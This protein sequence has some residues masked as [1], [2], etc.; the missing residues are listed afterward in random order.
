MPPVQSHRHLSEPQTPAIIVYPNRRRTRL[1]LF[2]GAVSSLLALLLFV[3][4]LILIIVIPATR[5]GG[6]I[7]TAVLLGGC[8]IAALWPTRLLASV[9]SSGEPMLVITH[10]VIRVG[11]VYGSFEIMLPWEEIEAIYLFGGGIEKQFCIRPTNVG[12]FLS[13]FGLLM[14]FFL[15][16]NL[17]TGAPLAVAQSFLEKPIAEILDQ[18]MARYTQELE[19]YHIQLRSPHLR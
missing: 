17:L 13:H 5:N 12:L 1:W 16:I 3:F 4:I 11:K 8:G 19:Y 14:R 6:A 18:V 9:L 7:A 2:L 10:Q 15:R